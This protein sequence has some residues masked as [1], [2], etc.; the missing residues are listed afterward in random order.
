MPSF[1]KVE[2]SSYEGHVFHALI[3]GTNTVVSE[4]VMSDRQRLYTIGKKVEEATN[5]EL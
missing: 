2:L 3:S 4:F 5:D 1:E